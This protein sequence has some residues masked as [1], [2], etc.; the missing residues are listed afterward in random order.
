MVVKSGVRTNFAQLGNYLI[1]QDKEVGMV[2]YENL[3]ERIDAAS[4]MSSFSEESRVE[5]PV[6]HIVLSYHK[7]DAPTDQERI[8]HAH[9]FLKNAGL[10]DHQALI[11]THNNTDHP[12]THIMV[13]RVNPHTLKA[14][15]LS[16]D[17]LKNREIARELE[18]K[19]GLVQTRD[20]N[21]SKVDIRD[22]KRQE[23]LGTDKSFPEHVRHVAAKDFEQSKSWNELKNR[24]Q[25]KGLFIKQVNNGFHITDGIEYAKAS[26]VSRAYTSANLSKR[27]GETLAEHNATQFK[28]RI[29]KA[30][31]GDFA[32]ATS[33]RELDS[34]L[35]K[36]GLV[37]NYDGETATIT[38]SYGKSARIEQARFDD[39][40]KRFKAPYPRGQNRTNDPTRGDSKGHQ[41]DR[42]KI[43]TRSTPKNRPRVSSRH[44]SGLPTTKD[45]SR[46][47]RALQSSYDNI[48][49]VSGERE[50]TLT[51]QKSHLENGAHRF[52]AALSNQ[53]Q[54]A[55]QKSDRNILEALRSAS[56]FSAK[57]QI[58]IKKIDL[59]NTNT[60][61]FK[62]DPSLA[63]RYTSI[64]TSLNKELSTIS[65]KQT[66][67]L[68]RFAKGYQKLS[69]SAKRSL[70]FV[71]KRFLRKGRTAGLVA[72]HI[73][74]KTL[75]KA[76]VNA[77]RAAVSAS[78][79]GAGVSVAVASL[80]T[81]HKL[82]RGL[83]SK[84]SAAQHGGTSITR[85]DQIS[86][87]IN[88]SR[89]R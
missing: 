15:K 21:V 20:V 63:K 88:R 77:A 34:K 2:S 44:D 71:S 86:R 61:K 23:L 26:K 72:K 40:A 58:L 9:E 24:L 60:K 50:I 78:I 68:K 51:S 4:Q 47:E 33:W 45:I 56:R 43:R 69:P 70:S 76:G 48:S 30:T 67:A 65:S 27:F 80:A 75:S 82:T 17:R 66:R 59:A 57:E 13:N 7:D 14:D 64:S 25:E 16:F 35:S 8:E 46:S 54:K 62:A 38:N 18:R 42:P 32:A 84:V 41:P 5:N 74:F 6:Y 83:Q 87:N 73:A 79:I 12:H 36:K 37:I 81:A 55:S 49:L 10:G 31:A 11:A 39:I 28:E 3:N 85:A 29:T 19:Y 53:I 1:T 89:S 22:I 52:T